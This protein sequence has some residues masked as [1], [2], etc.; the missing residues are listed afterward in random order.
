MSILRGKEGLEA[1]RGHPHQRKPGR[2]GGWG[3]MH[4]V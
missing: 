4:V 1:L 3:G 2:G